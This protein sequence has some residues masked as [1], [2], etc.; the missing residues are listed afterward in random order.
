MTKIKFLLFT[1][2][3]LPCFSG[4][5]MEGGYVYRNM[6]V[7]DGEEL[8]DAQNYKV[9]LSKDGKSVVL[10][11]VSRSDDM[12]CGL[13]KPNKW[14]TVKRQGEAEKFT[15][16]EDEKTDWYIQEVSFSASVNNSGVRRTEKI[17]L[18]SFVGNGTAAKIKV[19]QSR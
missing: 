10:K 4:C 5:I 6:Y 17:T 15:N 13:E 9:T 11:V 2:L 19:V 14:L 18:V 16:K 7:L 8:I 1:I 3:M 12:S